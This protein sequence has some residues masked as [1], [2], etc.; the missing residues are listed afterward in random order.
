VLVHIPDKGPRHDAVRRLVC[1]SSAG[2]AAEGGTGTGGRATRP[3]DRNFNRGR[4]S[5]RRTYGAIADPP[6][7]GRRAAA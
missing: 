4:S 1:Q 6:R 5:I 2:H 7:A 3:Q